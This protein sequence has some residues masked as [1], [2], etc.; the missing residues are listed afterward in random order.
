MLP[1]PFEFPACESKYH[2]SNKYDYGQED[3]RDPRKDR[4][5]M[6]GL[7]SST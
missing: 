4:T 6:E 3:G 7:A 5:V 1:S 2:Y